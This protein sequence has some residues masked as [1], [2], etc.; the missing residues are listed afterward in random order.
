MKQIIVAALTAAA[1]LPLATAAQAAGTAAGT[2]GTVRAK[3]GTLRDTCVYSVIASEW[4]TVRSY[5]Q[6]Q[7]DRPRT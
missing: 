1:I 2:L 5:L 3:D 4:P 7:P 6:W